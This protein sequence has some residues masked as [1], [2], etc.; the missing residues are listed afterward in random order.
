M[1][2]RLRKKLHR[3]YL[4]TV[5]GWLV[6]FDDQLRYKLLESE[7]G[8]PFRTEGCGNSTMRRF[9]RGRRLRYCV[10]VARKIAPATA[11]VVYWAE[12]FPTVRDEAVVFACSDLSLRIDRVPVSGQ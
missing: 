5:C 7:A 11:V 6:T 4:A 2:R 3:Q 12:D 8:T 1:N 9:V 10:M